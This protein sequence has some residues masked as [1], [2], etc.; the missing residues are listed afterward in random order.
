MASDIT[1]AVLL[2]ALPCCLGRRKKWDGRQIVH[3]EARA[4]RGSSLA[5]RGDLLD[6]MATLSQR[7]RHRGN[8]RH[9][10]HTRRRS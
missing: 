5:G 7:R 2:F 9:P 8:P 3:G 6:L 1:P 4:S 10:H